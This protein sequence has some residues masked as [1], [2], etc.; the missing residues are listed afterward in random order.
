MQ[1]G[2]LQPIV[3]AEGP[4]ASVHL[5]ATRAEATANHEVEL[6]WE[7]VRAQLLEQGAPQSVV[8]SIEGLALAQ[9]GLPGEQARSIVAT[10][11]GVLLDRVLPR[12]PVRDSGTYGPIPHLMPVVRALAGTFPYALVVADHTGA[13]VTF[14]DAVGRPAD[15]HEVEG[16][17]DVLHKYGGGGWSHRRFQMRVLDSWERNAEAVAKDLD[18]VVAQHAPELVVVGGDPHAKGYLR[19][20]ASERV[21]SLIQEVDGGSRAAG[22]DEEAFEERVEEVLARHR[23]TVMGELA[24]RFEQDRGRGG[25]IADG[26]GAVVDAL[27]GGAVDTLLLQDDASSTATLWAGDEPLHLGS[28]RDEVL[29]LG[30]TTAVEDR[31]DAVVVR[32]VAGQDARIELVEGMELLTGG[33]GALLR[34]DVRPPT[35]GRS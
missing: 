7:A 34:F 15:S 2:W 9:T 19:Q 5:D 23:Q 32:A 3:T 18:K 14:V 25:A 35:P 22:A 1:T 27:R 17:H 20:H 11:A 26:L 13:D 29:A 10:D 4:F 24:A 21:A 16:G 31:A 6:R 33:I 30:S 8:K 12:R 28:T